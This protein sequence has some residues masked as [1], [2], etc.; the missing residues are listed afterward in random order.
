MAHL[1]C[2]LE[3]KMESKVDTQGQQRT[4]NA[5]RLCLCRVRKLKEWSVCAM[6]GFFLGLGRGCNHLEDRI[7]VSK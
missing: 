3:E 6:M 4:I 1:M 5:F 7:P 2:L